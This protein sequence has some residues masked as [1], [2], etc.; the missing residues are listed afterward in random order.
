MVCR[1]LS[2]P[3]HVHDRG[4]RIS[5]LLWRKGILEGGLVSEREWSDAVISCFGGSAGNII[6]DQAHAVFSRKCGAV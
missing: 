1:P 4:Q 3:G 5:G 2:L 6:P